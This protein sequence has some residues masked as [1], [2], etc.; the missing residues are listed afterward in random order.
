VVV[1]RSTSPRSR[2]RLAPWTPERTMCDRSKACSKAGSWP[3]REQLVGLISCP[4]SARPCAWSW[5][6]RGSA[7]APRW[8]GGSHVLRTSPRTSASA[9]QD[10]QRAWCG[11]PASA[12]RG[13]TRTLRGP[14]QGSLAEPVVTRGSAWPRARS[15]QSAWPFVSAHPVPER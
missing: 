5:R 10:E 2:S 7:Q 1:T 15:G 8:T 12:H 4:E 3:D 11:A 9:L 13:A 14:S 6:R